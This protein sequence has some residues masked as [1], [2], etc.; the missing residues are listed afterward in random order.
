MAEADTTVDRESKL[1]EARSELGIAGD[2][3]EFGSSE[4]TLAP[5]TSSEMTSA[6][7]MLRD[8]IK[9]AREPAPAA[10]AVQQH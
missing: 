7:Q 5:L 9:A 1:A 4:G 10:A 8:A 3:R 2:V 6:A